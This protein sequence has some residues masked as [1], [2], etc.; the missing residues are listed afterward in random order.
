M[1]ISYFT[2]A[3]AFFSRF[4]PR[5]FW[6]ATLPGQTL[7]VSRFPSFLERSAGLLDALVVDD[8]NSFDWSNLIDPPGWYA[9]DSIVFHRG[10][11]IEIGLQVS[12]GVEYYDLA[13]IDIAAIVPSER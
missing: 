2:R 7:Y 3:R 6:A 9:V 8:P 10:G 1:A 4:L 11:G 12:E 13:E 5:S